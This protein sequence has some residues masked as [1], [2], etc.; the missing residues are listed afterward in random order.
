MQDGISSDRSSCLLSVSLLT[1]VL[2]QFPVAHVTCDS[3]ANS[4]VIIVTVV[5]V[6]ICVPVLPFSFC[7]HCLSSIVNDSIL[8]AHLLWL[9]PWAQMCLLQNIFLQ[10]IYVRHFLSGEHLQEHCEWQLCVARL[11]LSLEY[12]LNFW[13]SLYIVRPL[14]VTGAG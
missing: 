7:H 6:I 4:N 11:Y 13:Q 14:L 9:V 3:A 1:R 8:M 5:F 2:V 12:R 10:K